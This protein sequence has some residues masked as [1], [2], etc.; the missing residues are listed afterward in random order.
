MILACMN[1]KIDGKNLE[2]KLEKIEAYLKKEFEAEVVGGMTTGEISE[3]LDAMPNCDIQG[4]GEV[5]SNWIL[6]NL[7]QE[8]F[9]RIGD[10]KKNVSI[11]KKIDNPFIIAENLFK[12]YPYFE[13]I[14]ITQKMLDEVLCDID[15][16]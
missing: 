9:L 11:L 6:D 14:C 4:F 13:G 8:E 16:C 2:E 1:F 10:Y 7:D 3:F 5:C 15:Y 12:E